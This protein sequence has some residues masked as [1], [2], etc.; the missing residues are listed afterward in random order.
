M[1]GSTRRAAA[2]EALP[3]LRSRPVDQDRARIVI[4]PDGQALRS[5]I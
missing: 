1:A 5:L 4:I 3:Q 2:A